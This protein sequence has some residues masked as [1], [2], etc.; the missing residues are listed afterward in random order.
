MNGNKTDKVFIVML[1][2]KLCST[3]SE[4]KLDMYLFICSCHLPFTF[5]YIY[6]IGI[7]KVSLESY[8]ARIT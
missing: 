8:M 2:I 7:T 3:G 5:C 6:A 1:Y 4:R